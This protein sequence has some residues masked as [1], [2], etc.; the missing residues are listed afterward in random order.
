MA[1]RRGLLRRARK[2]LLQILAFAV[3][4]VLAKTVSAVLDEHDLIQASTPFP[5]IL[6]GTIVGM[7]YGLL[8]VGI[9][10]VYR[11]NRIINF[12][13]GQIGAFGAAFFGVAA[14]KWHIPYWIAFVMALVVSAATGAAA[15]AGVVRRLRGA[16]RIVSVVATLG[17][18]QLLV[19]AA[20][21][22][23]STAS[24][25]LYPQPAWLP[26]FNVGALRMTQ[27]YSGMLFL[28]PLFVLAIVLF[29]KRSRFGLAIRAAAA[30]PEAARM[31]GIF[32]SRMSTLAWAI[33][34]SLAG[35]AAI[36]TAPTQGFVGADSFGPALLLRALTAAV[37]GRMQSL[38]I[39][40]AS[41][42]GLGI[43][44]QL[45]MWNYPQSGLVE[46]AMFLII[47]VALLVQRRS[48]GR[49]EEK[50]SWAAV[51]GLRPIPERLRALWAVRAMGPA[52]TITALAALAAL[53]LFISNGLSVTFTGIIAFAIVGLSIG[54]LTGLGGQLT[55]GQFA[56]ASVGAVI[57]FKVSSN[58]G[59]F[60][61]A[62][63]LAGLGAG[64][65]SVVIGLP[66]L[67]IRGLML[68][69]TTLGFA[70]AAPAW[71]LTQPW[72]LGDG[73]DPEKPYGWPLSGPLDTGREYYYFALALFVLTLVLTRN[74]RRSGFSR[75]LIAIRDNEEN[76]R[77]FAVRASL[78][79]LQGYLIG[80]FIAGIG[81]ATYA[82]S[83]SSVSA[84][85]FPTTASID[86]AVMT[87]LGGVSALIGPVVGAIWVL[88]LP[89]LDIGNIGLA[90][91][92]FGVLLLILWKPGG[93][94]QVFAPIRDGIVKFIARRHGIDPDPLYA[95]DDPA[96][97]T[98]TAQGV[99]IGDL[100]VGEPAAA[101]APS[102]GAALLEA[103]DLR[104]SFG[105][106]HAV[107]GVSFAV[108]AGE[109]VGLIGPNGAGKTTTFELL[110][111][112]TKPDTG[113]VFLNGED[114]SKIG[115][116]G[117]AQ[118]GLIRSFQ[119]AALFP[120]MTV[121]ET[122]MLSL[123]RVQ[124]TGFLTSA[125]GLTLG[126]RKKERQ[127]R[128]LISA[129]GLDRYRDKP[130][131]EL[132]TGT[133]RIT[134]IACLVALQPMCLLL[135]EPSSGVAQR[136]T[137]ALGHLLAELKRE[138]DLTLVVIEHDIP[139]IMGISDRIIAMADGDLIAEGP[140]DVVRAHP[141]VVDAYL[142]GSITAI[143]RSGAGAV[144][145]DR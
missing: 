122:V 123:E 62:L 110:G 88:G 49:D 132:S 105:G 112:F 7:T 30:N 54:V 124:P 99:Q 17:V 108:R 84:G 72:M 80:G 85:S 104:K 22:I 21:L 125:L 64:L 44:E 63:L 65:V 75:L 29:L 18:G 143:E 101:A 23:N 28:S 103:R 78:V 69:V 45:L 113:R 5:V 40:L 50:G 20:A 76:A 8:A 70:L 120:T 51:Q 95:G 39:A 107:R 47:L 68:T 37:I 109:T 2:P 118:R 10:L 24:G 93:L 133:R 36:L 127:A 136:E 82:H 100:R 27:A 126:E 52:F 91:T 92:K 96:D 114:I 90:A 97:V 86:V 121:K 71:L 11:S 130:I 59:N 61:L 56:V 26:D 31:S 16:P 46:V 58:S 3:A 41:G 53:P 144:A 89:L 81:G 94:I 87:V 116:E 6:L 43:L 48:G 33:A 83:L 9:V 66:A 117:R 73:R 102:A 140:P 14:V 12:A 1:G 38:P 32:A 67:R 131:Q 111:G 15:E 141:Q 57:S 60:P 55:L 19:I 42:V 139:L 135:D 35:F 119:D 79:K 77:A 142:G 98:A 74:I 129:M 137:E 128:A 4:V 145:A 134:E 13:H 25:P 115:P 34:G 106:V 138:L